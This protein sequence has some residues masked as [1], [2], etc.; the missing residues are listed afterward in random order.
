ME[1]S[2]YTCGSNLSGEVDPNNNDPITTTISPPRLLESL[3]NVTIIQISCG[4]NHTAV[5]NESGAVLT[6]GNNAMMQLGRQNAQGIRAMSG[7]INQE[8]ARSVVC[9]MGY[10]AVLTETMR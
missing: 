4:Y 10:T 1:G 2:V 9:G 8:R 7:N 5:I 3:S 6:W